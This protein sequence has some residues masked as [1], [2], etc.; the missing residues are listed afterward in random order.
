[1]KKLVVLL[2]MLLP[3]PLKRR[4]YTAVLGYRLDPTASIGLSFVAPGALELAAGA[5]IGHLTVVK[6]V[7]LVRLGTR[8]VIGNMNWITGFPPG[9]SRHFAQVT[10]RRPQLVLGDE[11]AVTHRHIIDCTDSVEIGAFTTF[12]GFRSQI[13][14]HS[15]DLAA[16]RQHCAP[17]R[18]GERCFV[19]TA[20]VIL[21]G[22]ELPERS[23]LAAGA[24]L[25][26]A[27][28]EPGLHG[29][30]PA[31][32]IQPVEGAYFERTRGFVE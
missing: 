15:I 11:A 13:L 5:R 21:P 9:P 22:A 14:T 10:G 7:A 20:C 19:G 12:A 28:R 8:S 16:G 25:A 24:V 6:G 1:M 18:I 32:W 2:G 3:W 17:V 31:K 4:L 23:V 29:G 27:F 30:V 26:R